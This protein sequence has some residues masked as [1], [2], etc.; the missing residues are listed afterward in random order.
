MPAQLHSPPPSACP[1]Y[2]ITGRRGTG[3]TSWIAG[4]ILARAPRLFV[5]DHMAQL[6]A[7]TPGAHVVH[8]LPEAIR[9]LARAPRGGLA[10]VVYVPTREIT[11]TLFALVCRV[12]FAVPGLCLVIDEIDTFAGSVTPRP[13]DEFRRLV[14]F[15]RHVGCSIVGASRR[16]KDVSRLYTS[17][18]QLVCFQQSEPADLTWL[19]S[20]IGAEH[21]EEVAQLPELRFLAFDVAGRLT[22]RGTITPT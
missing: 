15:S 12:P 18:A 9:L 8:E 16:P 7:K 4:R 21:A 1:I 20:M 10:R 22:E 13:P 19:R 17:Q 14:H 3:K 11:P 2:L 5:F 6:A